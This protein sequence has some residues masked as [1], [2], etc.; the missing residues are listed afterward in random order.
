MRSSSVVILFCHLQLWIL[1]WTTT[2]AYE[3]ENNCVHCPGYIEGSAQYKEAVIMGKVRGT[4]YDY[5]NLPEFKKLCDSVA[6]LDGVDFNNIFD[7]FS[8]ERPA[9]FG[10]FF[11]FH[12]VVAN[13]KFESAGNHGFTGIFQGAEHG[14]LRFSPLVPFLKELYLINHFMG[15]YLFSFGVKFFRDG[16]H[17][18]NMNT[19]DTSVGFRNRA[20]GRQFYDPPNFNIFSRPVDNMSGLGEA[21]SPLFGEFEKFAGVLSPVDAAAY[22]QFGNEANPIVAPIYTHFRPNPEYLERFGDGSIDFRK[23]V[24]KEDAVRPG[25]VIYSLHTTVMKDTREASLCANDEGQP[26]GYEEDVSIYCPE[27]EVILIGN[28]VAKSR[29]YA[30][31]WPDDWLFFQHHRMCPKDQSVCTADN[32]PTTNLPY[33]PDTLGLGNPD[34]TYPYQNAEFCL[35]SDDTSGEVSNIPPTCPFGANFIK[36]DCYEGQQERVEAVQNQTCPAMEVL[37]DF[38]LTFADDAD[39]S[40]PACDFGF[41]ALNTFLTV[42]LTFTSPAI[43]GLIAIFPPSKFV[44]DFL[45]GLLPFGP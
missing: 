33:D 18:G 25:E 13:V 4:E 6:L 44:I 45:F 36:S 34:T 5:S 40:L 20:P 28:V 14:V 32:D 24:T 7:R 27:Q 11:H 22:D 37:A 10:R 26:L 39:L 1:P 35:S 29:F 42:F 3:Y 8:D 38:I 16:L 19:G 9:A 31:Q 15:T 21:F 43:R 23:W 41:T 2:T 12:G 17:S 30:S